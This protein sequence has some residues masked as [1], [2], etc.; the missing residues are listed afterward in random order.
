MTETFLDE[1]EFKTVEAWL[2]AA[3][4]MFALEKVIKHS[5]MEKQ[6]S[7]ITQHQQCRVE[8]FYGWLVS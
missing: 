4:N 3:T 1:M 2:N 7:Q 6:K 5:R 8:R